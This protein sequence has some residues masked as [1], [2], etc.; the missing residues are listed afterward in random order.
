MSITY[1]ARNLAIAKLVLPLT[2]YCDI[3]DNYMLTDCISAVTAFIFLFSMQFS[4][5]D[6]PFCFSIYNTVVSKV[7]PTFLV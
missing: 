7:I 6:I 2:T 4:Y 3:Y 5:S 1:P